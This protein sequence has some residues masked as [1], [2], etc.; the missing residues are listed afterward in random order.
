MKTEDLDKIIQEMCHKL[1][2][3]EY[4]DRSVGK[5]FFQQLAI[6]TAEDNIC[7]HIIEKMKK[8]DIPFLDEVLVILV[9]DADIHLTEKEI[10]KLTTV[11][12]TIYS[13][14]D[15][16]ECIIDSAGDKLQ[17]TTIQ[18]IA[19]NFG[20]DSSFFSDYLDYLWDNFLDEED[21]DLKHKKKLNYEEAKEWFFEKGWI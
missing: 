12:T 11:P 18:K 13:K 16:I 20:D 9:R 19:K 21:Q 8:E 3:V 7:S 6:L 14:E 10:V 5:E 17:K 1:E 15:F 4:T 2:S